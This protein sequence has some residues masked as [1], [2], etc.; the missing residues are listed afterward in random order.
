MSPAQRLYG[1]T[2]DALLVVHFAYVAFVVAG[3]VFI[4]LGHFLR[5][6]WVRNF[7]FRLAHLTAM[8]IVAFEAVT[9]IICPLTVWEERLRVMAGSGQ[10]YAGS[11]VQHWL[12]RILFYEASERVFQFLYVA[13]FALILLSLWVV[14]PRG[15]QGQAER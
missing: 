15:P 6:K 9:G 1:F 3:L 7:Y 2:A 11:F 13:F 5:W 8:G 12:H 10:S 14:K 4:W